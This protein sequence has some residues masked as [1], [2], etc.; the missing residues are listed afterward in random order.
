M[1]RLRRFSV[2]R[3]AT[4]V[5]L[6]YAV[7]VAVIVIPILLVVAAV[8]VQTDLGTG[9]PAVVGEPGSDPG[10]GAAGVGAAGVAGLLLVGLL[11]GALLRDHRLGLHCHRLPDLQPGGAMDRR[12]RGAGRPG[13]SAR[14]RAR[15]G[16]TEV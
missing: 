5:G 13:A 16:S 3:T 7:L 12:D 1:Y 14:A 6:M 8:G 2:V 10:G 15:L 9:G 11:G 4:V